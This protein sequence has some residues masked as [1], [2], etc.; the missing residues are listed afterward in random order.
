[1]SSTSASA[2]P[3]AHLGLTAD[4]LGEAWPY[5]FALD[6]TLNVVQVGRRLAERWPQLLG[7][8][9]ADGFTESRDRVDMRSA[10]SL[11]RFVGRGLVLLVGREEFPLRGAFVPSG[12]H[13]VFLG[14]PEVKDL[15]TLTQ[16]GLTLEDLP[17]H[18]GGRD[19]LFQIQSRVAALADAEAIAGKLKRKHKALRVAMK[20][21]K[22]ANDAK[23]AFLATV[24]H[25]IRTPM[26]AILGM[27]QLLDDG[28]LE[29]EQIDFVHTILRSGDALLKLINDILDL[30]KV[31]AGEFDL[32]VIPFDAA[33]P[34][35]EVRALLLQQ[36]RSKG[37]RIEV[38][39]RGSRTVMGDPHRMR[40]VL[41]NL[42]GNAIKFTAAGRVRIGVRCEPI[43]EHVAVQIEVQDTG[44]GI[45]ASAQRRIFRPFSQADSSTTRVYG[46]TGLGL[47]IC[48]E[49]VARMGGELTLRSEVGAGSTFAFRVLLPPSA[50][51]PRPAPPTDGRTDA[52][53]LRIL[54]V[55]DVSMNRTV[56]GTAL[57]RMGHRIGEAAD[58]PSAIEMV[59]SSGPWDLVLMDVQMPG[60][61]GMAATRAIRQDLGKSLPIVAV[62]AH[63]MAEHAA[64]A[65]AAGMNE[66]LTKPIQ[67]DRLR[68]LLESISSGAA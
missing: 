65:R 19:L 31:E 3:K 46:G 2:Q 33:Q 21:A 9:L 39:E 64:A 25:E 67:F 45:P 48:R 42:V 11:Q 59:A 63:A 30:S 12:E 1:M 28:S 66:V 24:S 51:A 26:N 52:R 44:I 62:T 5:H 22:A 10:Q 49:I 40:Q 50:H 55:D 58:G 68:E 18:D 35:R 27:A 61:D 13:L 38:Q 14:A 8:P 57:K 23:S 54:V 41:T 16:R 6:S 29:G 32:E 36:A 53:V 43:G 47:A 4:A 15:D 17:A 60:M 34:A 37:L 7:R 20:E 56:L